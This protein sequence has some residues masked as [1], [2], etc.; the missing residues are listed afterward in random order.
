MTISVISELN[1]YQAIDFCHENKFTP[2][3]SG[4]RVGRFSPA[5]TNRYEVVGGGDATGSEPVARRL[6]Y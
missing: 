3:I 1:S 6:C 5:R 4:Y 2:R